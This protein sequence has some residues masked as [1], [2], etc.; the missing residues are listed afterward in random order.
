M[1]KGFSFIEVLVSV[2]IL[3][4]MGVALIKFNSF[5]K[6]AMERNIIKQESIL[7]TGAILYDTKLRINDEKDIELLELV[8]F[9]NLDDKDRDFL[10]SIELHIS[11]NLEDRLILGGSAGEDFTQNEDLSSESQLVID[12]E[13]SATDELNIEYGSLKVTYKEYTQ[14]YLWAQK[15]E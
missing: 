10:R 13:V 11:K 15:E 12:D 2:A 1:R 8:K 14:N 9:Q 4:F 5:N 7:L 6:R 3:S